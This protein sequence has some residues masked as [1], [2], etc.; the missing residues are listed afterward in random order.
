MSLDA[1]RGMELAADLIQ[2][3]LPNDPH[4]G[5]AY[6]GYCAHPPIQRKT[7]STPLSDEEKAL[8]GDAKLVGLQVMFRHGARI[9]TSPLKTCFNVPNYSMEYSCGIRRVFQEVGV[10]LDTE[11]KLQDVYPKSTGRC[12]TGRLQDVAKSQFA[13]LASTLRAQ[14]DFEALGITPDRVSLRADEVPRTQASMYLLLSHLFPAAKLMKMHVMPQAVDHWTGNP[15]CPEM[16]K[17]RSALT[18]SAELPVIPGTPDNYDSRMAQLWTDVTGTIFRPISAKDCLTEAACTPQPLPKGFTKELFDWAMYKSL[19]AQHLKYASKPVVAKVLASQV[20]F[21][22]QDTFEAQ[23]KENR[24]TSTPSLAL[25]STHDTTL[26]QL[27]VAMDLWDGQWPTYAETLI[28]EAYQGEV[29]GELRTSFRLVRRGQPLTIPGCGGKTICSAEVL[30]HLGIP[31]LRDPRQMSLYCYGL[32][33]EEPAAPAFENSQLIGDYG[34][35]TNKSNNSI[36]WFAAA[37]CLAL[38]SFI[39]GTWWARTTP[40]NHECYVAVGL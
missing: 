17:A 32:F 33:P 19:K 28:L 37:L 31:S 21:D 14:Y 22:L 4:V 30:M 9:P 7:V 6:A 23:T 39:F 3:W 13:T 11:L 12:G 20:L 24:D 38:S 36:A 15:D 18:E 10:G 1:T 35:N 27:L 40:Q 26:I 34:E 8:L 25:I 16:L 5:A 29:A 2:T